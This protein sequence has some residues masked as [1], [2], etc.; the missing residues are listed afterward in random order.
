[1]A[2][3]SGIDHV[4]I[5]VA[6][7]ETSS[8]FYRDLLD[9]EIALEYAPGDRVLIRQIVIGSALLS[10]HQAGNGLDLV[11]RHPT[12]GAADICLSWNDTIESAMALLREKRVALLEGPVPVRSA[13]NRPSQS[14]YFHDPDGNLV[15]LMATDGNARSE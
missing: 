5:T 7:L 12:I 9:A 15:E 11:A 3:V 14:I 13:D 6:D 10:L 4:A 1:M 8:A 2:G